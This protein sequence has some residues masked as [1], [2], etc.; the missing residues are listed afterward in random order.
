MEFLKDKMKERS[1]FYKKAAL[2]FQNKNL[3]AMD[4]VRK[5]KEEGLL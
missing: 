3:S 4:I 5:L 2:E 1:P